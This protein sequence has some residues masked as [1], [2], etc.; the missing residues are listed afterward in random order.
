M[1]DT[2]R[3][4]YP[5]C[6]FRLITLIAL[7]ALLITGCD[8]LR[9]APSERQKQNAWLHGRTTAVA[10]DT[11]R[12]E[13]ASPALQSLTKLSELQSRAFTSYCGLPK[14]YPPAEAADDIVAESNWQLATTA[15]AE[16]VERPDP[17]K[18][19][20]SVLEIG[21]GISALLGGVYGTRAVRFLKDARDKSQAL[22]EIV[23]GNE[24]FK[25]QNESAAAAFKTAQAS[26]S[27]ETR[28]LVA[29]LKA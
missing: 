13:Q 8:S 10:A 19:A 16:S 20:D 14:E 5:A 3:K 7:L 9:L 12:S 24:R 4:V 25:R 27:P 11:A 18:V 2:L 22:G 15:L 26:Q 21:I 29:E 17:W 6:P 23:T 28:Q 1:N